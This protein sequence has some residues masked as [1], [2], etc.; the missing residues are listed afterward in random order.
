MGAEGK[1]R[2][3]RGFPTALTTAS[4][5]GAA[6]AERRKNGGFGTSQSLAEAVARACTIVMPHT[7]LQ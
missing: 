3:K 6:T 1:K 7:V 5:G 2:P 4:S